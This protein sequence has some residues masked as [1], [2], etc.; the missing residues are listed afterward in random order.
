MNPPTPPRFEDELEKRFFSAE[1]LISWCSAMHHASLSFLVL[2]IDHYTS[3][4]IGPDREAL[5]SLLA[6]LEDG[7]EGLA[8]ERDFLAKLKDDRLV[9]ASSESPV[10]RLLERGRAL[11]S[12]LS[13]HG[14]GPQVPTVSGLV[15]SCPHDCGYPE[16]LP[17][18]LDETLAASKL[19]GRGRVR[20]ADDLPE[21]QERQAVLLVDDEP[22]VRA[23]HR[24]YLEHAGLHVV[25]AADGLEALERIAGQPFDLVVLDV[26]MPR[27]DGIE[28]VRRLKRDGRHRH[29]PVVIL[30]GQSDRN[31]LLE[32]FRAGADEFL[33]K[34]V[35]RVEFTVRVNSM[36]VQKTQ[37]DSLVRHSAIF[38]G[39]ASTRMEF[40]SG[41]EITAQLGQVCRTLAEV[42]G[43]DR[44]GVFV[45]NGRGF[46]LV[47]G[48]EIGEAEI[49]WTDEVY[50]RIHQLNSTFPFHVSYRDAEK[51][52]R[53]G[54]AQTLVVLPLPHADRIAADVV[55]GFGRHLDLDG[56]LLQLLTMFAARLG[57]QLLLRQATQ[58]LEEQ[59]RT[60]T[61][62]LM[63]TI[64]ELNRVAE[65]T[66]YRLS[67]AS[68]FRDNETGNHV[69]RIGYY[70]EAIA[71]AMGLSPD[72]IGR[73]RS[74][75]PMHDL[76]KIGIP[77][78]ILLKPGRFT[79]EEFEVM[80]SH[81][82]IGEKILTGSRSSLMEMARII[83]LTHH[84]RYDGTGYP[85]GLRTEE[86]PLE[87]RIVALCDVFDAL[88]SK[89]VYKGAMPLDQVMETLSADRDKY[90]PVVY[91]A[92]FRIL[93][94]TILPIF[95][96][97]QG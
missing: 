53:L 65:D 9:L 3:A 43:F 40:P 16:Q 1:D 51:C 20:K 25:E 89:R 66:I 68:E 5:L 55:V 35:T 47:V 52:S 96:R 44:L 92:F 94:Q 88:M 79:P 18:Y 97:Y 34:P 46:K 11:L 73:I 21:R 33:I 36:L 87:G 30:T 74:A 28:T 78:H 93:E 69:K 76:G 37:R 6:A 90:D 8:G 13:G 4:M 86:I 27:L 77:D 58:N 57:Q 85:R 54:L 39:L 83:A 15:F 75:A 23:I 70:A 31:T 19:H 56:D 14:T 60:K 10:E 26:A 80:K 29:L 7:L 49:H 95:V 71:E 82:E 24:A 41:G 38:R 72:F 22:E 32:A 42:V 62:E 81:T 48:Y 50:A 67:I 84:E 12:E 63:R 91:T 2:D 61:N 64:A 17:A 45:R 59:V